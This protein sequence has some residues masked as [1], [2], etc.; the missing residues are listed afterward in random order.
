MIRGG[1]RIFGTGR[2]VQ[3]PAMRERAAEVFAKYHERIRERMDNPRTKIG[4][5][6]MLMLAKDLYEKKTNVKRGLDALGERIDGMKEMPR[7]GVGIN[8]DA[9]GWYDGCGRPR[10][11]IMTGRGAVSRFEAEHQKP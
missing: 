7:H 9:R 2:K 8:Q 1:L 3:K 10:Y 4:M 11:P 6:V 5:L